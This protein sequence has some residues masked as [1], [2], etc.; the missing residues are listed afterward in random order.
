[1]YAISPDGQEVAYTSNI[2]EVEAAS[3]NNEIF[4]VP[5]TVESAVPSGRNRPVPAR[6]RMR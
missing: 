1:M 5:I 3:T 2:D 4:I 6:T